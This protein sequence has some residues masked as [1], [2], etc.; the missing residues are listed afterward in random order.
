MNN[1]LV[2]Q[3]S[4]I[5]DTLLTTPALAAL[6]AALPGVR[7]TVMGHPKRGEVVEHLPGVV[8]FVPAT[9]KTVAWRGW[10]G[11][12]RY[13]LALVYGF[14]APLLRYA[15]RTA[16]KVVAYT[17]PDA[18]LNA[19][20][21][22]TV[23][24]PMPAGMHWV[25]RFL[26]LVAAA[27]YAVPAGA[28]HFA[29]PAAADSAAPSPADATTRAPGTRRIQYRVSP[30]ESAAARARIVATGLAEAWPRIGLQVAS[31]PTKA[32]RDWPLEH[33]AALSTALRERWPQAGFFLYGG[34][35]DRTRTMALATILGTGVA[36]FAGQLTLRES[37]ALM[38]RTHLYVG[39]DTGPTH[40][41]SAFDIPMVSLYHCLYPSR[42]YGPLD[43]PHAAQ[44]DHPEC[45]LS[46]C[47]EHSAMAAITV[48]DVLARI[49]ALAPAMRRD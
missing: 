38:S 11:G 36:N 10:V 8:R 33:F 32:H 21:A 28:A 43:H 5:G 37:G 2:I 15:L 44:I 16:R 1:V 42:L 4:R 29:A 26:A 40:L 24:W 22:A 25:D 48:A 7:I 23:P 13:D 20:L 31:F 9:K 12:P 47:S 41:M 3:V 39:V 45:G 49:D 17:Q 35:D 18:A 30:A 6:T 19:R 34:P 46:S 27:G 14:D